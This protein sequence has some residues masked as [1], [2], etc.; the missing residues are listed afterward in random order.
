MASE[1]FHITCPICYLPYDI[2]VHIPRLITCTQGHTICAS[3]ISSQMKFQ[4]PFQ[5]PFDKELI[6]TL[7]DTIS[8]FPI[9]RALM[10]M[11]E[12]SGLTCSIHMDKKRDL[13]CHECKIHICDRCERKGDHSG[14]RVSILEDAGEETKIKLD[15]IKFLIDNFK[16]EVELYKKALNDKENY[17]LAE[18]DQNFIQLINLLLTNRDQVRY[19]IK[20]Y[21]NSISD[22]LDSGIFAKAELSSTLAKWNSIIDQYTRSDKELVQQSFFYIVLEEDTNLLEQEMQLGS[23]QT[24]DYFKKVMKEVNELKFDFDIQSISDA[25][26]KGCE[27]KSESNFDMNDHDHF[28]WKNN[29]DVKDLI[30]LIE[31]IEESSFKEYAVKTLEIYE[32][33]VEAIE[34]L[35]SNGSSSSSKLPP[36]HLYSFCYYLKNDPDCEKILKWFI[37]DSTLQNSE[38]KIK[39]SHL[40][41]DSN[42]YKLLEGQISGLTD[43]FQLKELDLNEDEKRLLNIKLQEYN[44]KAAFLEQSNMVLESYLNDEWIEACSM[45]DKISKVSHYHFSFSLIC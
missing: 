28:G 32:N 15:K 37:L 8:R 44:N 21:I 29:W 33:R 38:K 39:L 4:Q 25:L 5:C 3:C 6:I 24:Q 35:F 43:T 20:K 30:G 34:N 9:N 40:K 31:K 11:I 19:T 14:H 18:F 22:S 7:D 42:L 2:N 16:E 36:L 26:V 13:I 27:I 41:L 23:L 1:A 45:I 12:E 17:L 10:E